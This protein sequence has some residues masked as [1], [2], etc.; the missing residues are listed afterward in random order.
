M[1]GHG[2]KLT[3]K[4][5]AVISALLSEP[6]H[7]D[8]ARKANIGESTLYRWLA[9]DEFQ[10]AYRDA[11]R[12]IVDHAVSRLCGLTDQAV[13]ALERNLTCGKAPAEIRAAL[14]ILDHVRAFLGGEELEQIIAALEE[15][16]KVL[17]TKP[18]GQPVL[19]N[20]RMSQ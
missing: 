8:A 20:G 12:Q 15:K 14:G 18:N 2:Q 3:R 1:N 4:Q 10:A 13:S 19:F 11:R 16:I 17:E 6:T 5:E 9:R 7:A